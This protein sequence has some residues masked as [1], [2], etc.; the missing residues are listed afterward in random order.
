MEFGTVQKIGYF[1]MKN[2]SLQ[3]PKGR[4]TELLTMCSSNAVCN[5]GSRFAQEYGIAWNWIRLIVVEGQ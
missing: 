2:G 5:T 4:P 3:C 1:L